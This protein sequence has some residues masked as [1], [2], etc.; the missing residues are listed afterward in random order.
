MRFAPVLPARG[1]M[2]GAAARAG[3]EFAG[4]AVLSEEELYKDSAA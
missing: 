4:Q 1:L 2:F 3:K